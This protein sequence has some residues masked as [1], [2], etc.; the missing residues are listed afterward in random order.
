MKTPHPGRTWS[1]LFV[2][3]AG[4]V[5]ILG[6]AAWHALLQGDPMGCTMNELE[7]LLVPSRSD[8]GIHLISYALMTP[9]MGAMF[10]WFSAWRHQQ[11][12]ISKLAGSLSRITCRDNRLDSTA[13]KLGLQGKVS[14]IDSEDMLSFCAF[15]FSPRIFISRGMVNALADRELEAVLVHE[16]YHLVN[17]DPL[18]MFVGRSLVSGLFFAPVLKDLFHRYLSRKEI[19]ADQ[20]AIAYQ[21]HRGGIVGALRKLVEQNAVAPSGLTLTVGATEELERR[22]AFIVG[23]PHKE[24][25]NLSHTL[26]SSAV[27][28]L[29]VLSIVVPRTL[30]R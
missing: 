29:S 17:R 20:S 11:S 3:G 8:L 14:L 27:P 2:L 9:L 12:R 6:A 24:H 23:R 4:T 26:V 15:F 10:F 28:L 19:A 30:I 21:A 13:G 22:V 25:L 5:F 1:I 7:C 18:R 16:K